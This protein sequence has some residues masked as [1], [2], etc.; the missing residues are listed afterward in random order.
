MSLRRF[1]FL[2]LFSS[3]L[4]PLGAVTPLVDLASESTPVILTVRD[5]PALVAQWNQSPWA[6]TWNDEQVKR[7]F[8]PLRSK[9]K[10]DE[11]SSNARDKTGYTVEE[12]LAFAT[13]EAIVM[14]SDLDFTSG[15]I[16]PFLVGIEVG[17]NASKIEAVIAKLN[18]DE[19]QVE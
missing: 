1:A 4:L 15:R 11:W 8:A 13:G 17:E 14:V 16:L 9:W 5:M 2:A 3:G 6:K 10:V 12:L 19:N 18:E 7:F